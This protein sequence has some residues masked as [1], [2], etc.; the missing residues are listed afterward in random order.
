MCQTLKNQYS[1]KPFILTFFSF[2]CIFITKQIGDAEEDKMRKAIKIL[3][4]VMISFCMLSDLMI[5]VSAAGGAGG[6]AVFPKAW[7]K[8]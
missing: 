1:N 2:Y 6:G 8:A 4:A 5:P 3:L 7:Y